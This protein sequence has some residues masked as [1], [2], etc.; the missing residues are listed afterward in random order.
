[1][2]TRGLVG[3]GDDALIAGFIVGD[4]ANATVAVRALGPSLAS[5]NIS[6]PLA[7]PSLAIY[8][9][10]GI[11]LATND[12]WQ[13]DSNQI[14]LQQNGLAPTDPTEA[15]TILYLPAGAY[16]AIVS[17]ADGGT[18]VGLVEVYDLDPAR[19]ASAVR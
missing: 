18:G 19:T 11:T 6:E 2:S 4:V 1:M 15:A 5:H 13:D 12:N 14:D 7:N 8:D 10:N 16:S 3:T 9:R 17:G